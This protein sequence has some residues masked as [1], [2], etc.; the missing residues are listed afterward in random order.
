MRGAGRFGDEFIAHR[1][2]QLQT[3]LSKTAD[4]AVLQLDPVLT[5]FLT[6]DNW[7]GEMKHWTRSRA[8]DGHSTPG[9]GGGTG[10][11][12]KGYLASLTSGL[13]GPKFVE[14]DD[15]FDDRR[16]ALDTLEGQLKALVKSVDLV[17]K[18]RLGPSILF[19]FLSRLLPFADPLLPLPSAA[20]S[21]LQSSP[22]QSTISPS[23]SR[24]SPSATSRARWRLPSSAFRTSFG[25]PRRRRKA[26]AG[27]TS[28]A[29]WRPPTS[30]FV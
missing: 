3:F 25:G 22:A 20:S 5:A 11:S 13:T 4:H 19:P 10:A 12:E 21:Y 24:R 15:W 26:T 23:Q 17:S 6:A 18:Q 27:A 16:A 14:R 2:A 9:G 28:A 30:T 8:L 1:R 29:S 7:S